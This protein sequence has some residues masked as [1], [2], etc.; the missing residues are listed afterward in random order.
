MKKLKTNHL[1]FL[2]VV[3]SLL[4]IISCQNS[5]GGNF[6]RIYPMESYTEVACP[7][8]K[9]GYSVKFRVGKD[10]E[11]LPVRYSSGLW[12]PEDRSNKTW[13]FISYDEAGHKVDEGRY[14][15][16]KQNGQ[17]LGWHKN[18]VKESE[19]YFDTGMPVGKFTMWHD[20]GKIAVQGEYS[21]DW[22]LDGKWVYT[23]ARGRTEKIIVWNKGTI[24]SIKK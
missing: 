14:L 22:K 20:N 21:P 18:G 2:I 13:Y 7:Q 8:D 9:K 5:T 12:C 24:V 1:C 15:E 6:P 10:T 23:D 3:V 19:G 16:G 11:A 17:W 4:F